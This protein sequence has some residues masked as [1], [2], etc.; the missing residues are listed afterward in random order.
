M[1]IGGKDNPADF[2]T[3]NLATKDYTKHSEVFVSDDNGTAI[4]DKEGLDTP[5]E[6]KTRKIWTFQGRVSGCDYGVLWRLPK[7]V[8]MSQQLEKTRVRIRSFK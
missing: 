2:F 1:W 8:C 6:L 5:K 7:F 4:K 3:E